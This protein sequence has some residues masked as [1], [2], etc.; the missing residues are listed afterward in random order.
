[1]RPLPS[2]ALSHGERA[3]LLA[4]A[5]ESRF[6]AVPPARIVSM[7]ADEGIYLAIVPRPSTRRAGQD[8]LATGRSSAP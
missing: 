4:V 5:N 8:Q 2:H 3:K 6:A 1:M 7:L